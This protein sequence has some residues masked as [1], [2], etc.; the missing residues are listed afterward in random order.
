MDEKLL[1]RSEAEK[2]GIDI[3]GFASCE[4]FIEVEDILRDREKKGYLSGFE[5]QDVEKRIYPH[6]LMENCKTFI[7]AGISYGAE[8]RCGNNGCTISMCSWGTDYHTVLRNKLNSL[9]EFIKN[10]FNCDAG[11]FVDTGPIV[12]R[13]AARRAG[14]GFVGKNCSVINPRYGSFIFLGEIITDLFVEPDSPMDDGCG[15]CDICVKACPTGALC[16]PYT[17]NAKKCISYL[18]QS[19]NISPEDYRK[20]GR[21]IYGCDV[22]QRVC[23]KNKVRETGNHEEFMPEEWNMHPDPYA[24]LNGSKKD[25]ENTFKKTSSGWRGRKILQR[26]ALISLGNSKGSEKE[27]AAEQ[28]KKFLEDE[29]KDI[30]MTAVIALHN[31]LGEESM[32]LIARVLDNERDEDNRKGILRI[33]KDN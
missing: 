16:A 4:P 13:E 28:I 14:I 1:I 32:S 33:L 29:R 26:N 6:R 3:I 25:F 21:S 10:K 2:L 31:L 22:C 20:I 27:K 18:T 12:E 17:V 24:I 9:G 19:K 15:D 11:I 7:S 5:E 23:P 30:R 8:D